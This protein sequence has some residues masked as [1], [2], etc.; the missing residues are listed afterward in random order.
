M[1]SLPDIPGKGLV[2][3]TS[4]H[5]GRAGKAA[6]GAGVAMIAVGG[7]VAKRLIGRGRGAGQAEPPAEESEADA[8]VDL[9]PP[10]EDPRD[11]PDPDA[12][13]FGDEPENLND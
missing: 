1:A 12:M 8:E 5:A 7:Y 10:A 3:G 6:I 4:R 2:T 9:P 13:S 11:P